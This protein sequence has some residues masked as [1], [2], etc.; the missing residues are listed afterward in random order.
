VKALSNATLMNRAVFAGIEEGRKKL[1][2]VTR[3][4]TRII[5]HRV[6]SMPLRPV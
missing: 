6:L 5:A 2:S 4:Q 1:A 3:S